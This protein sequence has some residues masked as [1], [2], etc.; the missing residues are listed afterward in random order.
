MGELIEDYDRKWTTETIEPWM[1]I[2]CILGENLSAIAGELYQDYV[3]WCLANS[4]EWKPRNLTV[5]GKYMRSF[6]KYMSN[7]HTRYI[8]ITLLKK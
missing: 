2:R 3:Q 4:T 8:G 5:W 7:G 6:E 1:K